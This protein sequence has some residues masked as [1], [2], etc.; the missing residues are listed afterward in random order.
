MEQCLQLEQRE[1]D[2][3][4]E[5]TGLES[6]MRR[7]EERPKAMKPIDVDW[8]G[9]TTPRRNKRK[10][11]LDLRDT[12]EDV[13][14]SGNSDTESET[15]DESTQFID[16]SGEIEEVEATVVTTE[17]P[18][19]NADTTARHNEQDGQRTAPRARNVRWNNKVR[20]DL[21]GSKRRDDDGRCTA[22]QAEKTD[23]RSMPDAE[24]ESQEK[25]TT[26]RKTATRHQHRDRKRAREAEHAATATEQYRQSR[27]LQFIAGDASVLP[28]ANNSVVP[29][30]HR[31]ILGIRVEEEA[32]VVLAHD[33]TS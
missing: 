8:K 12:N 29:W 19:W 27:T 7:W 18:V 16:T 26:K 3:I 22:D 5:G 6:A 20:G 31:G 4:I 25:V 9:K 17:Q 11:D 1:W 15:D 33:S 14:I 13:N 28:K 21:C 24:A 32:Q 23:S 10:M 2:A 30:E